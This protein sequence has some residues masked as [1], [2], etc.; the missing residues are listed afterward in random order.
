[1]ITLNKQEQQY[2]NSDSQ[3]NQDDIHKT[4]TPQMHVQRWRYGPKTLKTIKKE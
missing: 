3:E 2:S 1:M 4:N